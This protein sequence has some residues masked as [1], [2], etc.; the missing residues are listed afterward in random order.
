MTCEVAVLNKRVIALAADS[1]VTLTDGGGQ[2][3]KIYYTADK[4]FS[5]SPKLP[6]A[7]TTYGP[8]EIM[9]VPWK[10]VV[11]MYAQRLDGRRFDRLAAYAQDF[12]GFIEG[13]DW[14]SPPTAQKHRLQSLICN[15]WKRFL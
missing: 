6:V 7:I 9:G 2:R 5:L 8:A 10:T 3:K 15:V 1:A 11:K 12:L 14:L 4:L 13:A